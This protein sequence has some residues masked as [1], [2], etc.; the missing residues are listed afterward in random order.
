MTKK[1]INDKLDGV[2]QEVFDDESLHVGDNTTAAEVDGWDSLTHIV[3][4]SEIEDTFG[5]KFSMR[6]IT[7]LKNVGELITR[8]EALCH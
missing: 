8:I 1:E 3:L 7:T 4:M 2:F 6:D 5:I